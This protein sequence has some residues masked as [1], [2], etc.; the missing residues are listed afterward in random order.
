MSVEKWIPLDS[1][2]YLGS[3]RI[4]IISELPF[5]V[6]A[7]TP[8]KARTQSETFLFL[9]L[10]FKDPLL[11]FFLWFGWW[12]NSKITLRLIHMAT[13]NIQINEFL[14]YLSFICGG[15]SQGKTQGLVRTF[16]ES[17]IGSPRKFLSIGR[18]SRKNIS[19][20]WLTCMDLTV[21]HF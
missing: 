8:V 3:N 6:L 1:Q 12:V 2:D 17:F 13:T 15:C 7:A 4:S 19:T 11:H 9:Y 10:V 18:E 5:L 21:S 20:A 14:P 16:Q